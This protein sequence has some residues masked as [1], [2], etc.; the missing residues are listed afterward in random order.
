[1]SMLARATAAALVLATSGCEPFTGPGKRLVGIIDRGP[2]ATHGTLSAGMSG[3]LAVDP[4]TSA[5]RAPDTVQAGV[6]FEVEVATYG[7]DMCWKAA[8]AETSVKDEVAV[9]TPYDS[10]SRPAGGGCWDAEIRLPRTVHI[11]FARSGNATLRVH[12]RKVTGL[13]YEDGTPITV[14][15]NI[16]VR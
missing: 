8:G 1:M 12:G 5:V 4:G 16:Y 15:K 13:K 6:P 10:D 14:E 2:A 11:T 7:L 3:S 9:I